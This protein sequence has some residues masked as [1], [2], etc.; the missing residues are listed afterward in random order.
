MIETPE[1]LRREI[2]YRV[3]ERIGIM[4]LGALPSKAVVEFAENEARAW[5]ELH[6]PELLDNESSSPT[7]DD[8]AGGAERKQIP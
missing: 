7:A 5:A 1:Q 6:Y 2:A 4:T 8:D 3:D